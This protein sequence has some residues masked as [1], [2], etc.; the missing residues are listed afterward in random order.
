MVKLLRLRASSKGLTLTHE[1]DPH[2]PPYICGDSVRFRQ[3]L[4]NLIANAIKFTAQGGVH[5]RLTAT[6]DESGVYCQV[7][8]SGIGVEES[9]RERIFE[10]FFQADGTTRRR[11]GGTGLGLTISKQLVETMGGQIGTYN[12]ASGPGAT[13]WFQLPLRTA[14]AVVVESEAKAAWPEF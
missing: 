10:A 2:L 1:I 4:T 9:V 5:I 13:F 12:N 6:E 3:I 14:N 11:Y 7:I 8:D